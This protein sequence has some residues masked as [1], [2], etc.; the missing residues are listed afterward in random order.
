MA[1]FTGTTSD[2]P[3]LLNTIRLN[4]ISEGWTINRYQTRP[5]SPSIGI[6]FYT[7]TEGEELHVE[8][9][10]AGNFVIASATDNIAFDGLFRLPMLGIATCTSYSSG[11]GTADQPGASPFSDASGFEDAVVE[12]H[13][14]IESNYCHV[15]TEHV[16]NRYSHFGF[17]KMQKTWGYSGGEYCH[18]TRWALQNNVINNPNSGNHSFPFDTANP[19]FSANNS[20]IRCDVNGIS[21]RYFDTSNVEKRMSNV[22]TDCFNSTNPRSENYSLFGNRWFTTALSTFSGVSVLKEMQIGIRT[23]DTKEGFLI[24]TVPEMR[25]VNMTNLNPKQSIIY[26][27][28]EW[29]VF[30]IK[31]KSTVAVASNQKSSGVFGMAYRKVV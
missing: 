17:G 5:T 12:Y 28:D 30:P 20:I 4:L 6:G 15:V 19:S 31:F 14:F 16:G 25:N 26:G 2:L 10:N 3:S 18:G 27:P 7:S 29:I 11:L 24:G 21:P 8:N 23:A 1:Y 9:A 22:S 13:M